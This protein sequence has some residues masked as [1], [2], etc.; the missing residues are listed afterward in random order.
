M[1]L[2]DGSLKS[3]KVLGDTDDIGVHCVDLLVLLNKIPFYLL[4]ISF[5][6]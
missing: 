1:D 6:R 4:L 3:L 5:A 2:I